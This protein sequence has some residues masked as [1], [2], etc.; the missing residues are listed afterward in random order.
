MQEPII[1]EI[2]EFMNEGVEN[3]MKIE[4]WIEMPKKQYSDARKFE[5]EMIAR[6][7]NLREIEVRVALSNIWI[8]MARL[9]Q[10]RA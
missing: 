1:D 8:F 3:A 5:F 6:A 9:G 10:R 2:A 4:T 7:L